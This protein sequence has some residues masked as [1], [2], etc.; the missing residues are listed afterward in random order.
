MS[1]KL[2]KK[3]EGVFGYVSYWLEGTKGLGLESGLK[4]VAKIARAL[5]K[6]GCK[7]SESIRCDGDYANEKEFGDVGQMWFKTVSDFEKAIPEI[8][9]ANDYNVVMVFDNKGKWLRVSA[10]LG[11]ELSVGVLG[12]ADTAKAAAKVVAGSVG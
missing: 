3:S 12:D 2:I 9:E 4:A 6:E 1:M 11:G 10:G 5:E 7:L 8:V